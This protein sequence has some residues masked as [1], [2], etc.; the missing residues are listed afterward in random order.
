MF[1]DL[2]AY[3]KILVTGPQ[4][5]G[6]TICAKMIAQD[7]GYKFIDE[8]EFSVDNT[9]LFR[10]KLKKDGIVLQCPAM[11]FCIQEFSADDTLIIFMKRD[12]Q[13]ILESQKRVMWN[14]AAE[15]QKYRSRYH[16]KKP[17][18]CDAKYEI[19]DRIQKDQIKHW[20]EIVYNSLSE[21]ELWVPKAGRAQF[22]VKQTV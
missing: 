17:N 2:T 20:K 7:T 6:T 19:W 10:Q 4:R 1:E 5:S 12:T 14:G 8:S 3:K 21:H 16:I 18:I 13:S 11:S 15:E 9:D 22:G